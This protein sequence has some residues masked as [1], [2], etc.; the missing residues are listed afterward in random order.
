MEQVYINIPFIRIEI[1]F[2]NVA[3]ENVDVRMAVNIVWYL[4]QV[5][6]KETGM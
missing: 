1:N 4:I 2:G 5:F 6:S 3:A